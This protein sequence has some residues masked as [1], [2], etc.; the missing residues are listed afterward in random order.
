MI[1]MAVR[2]IRGYFVVAAS[3]RL[4][5]RRRGSFR[6]LCLGGGHNINAV[7]VISIG[8]G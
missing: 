6:R 3:E 1:M 5:R 8:R 7:I 2:T 4:L